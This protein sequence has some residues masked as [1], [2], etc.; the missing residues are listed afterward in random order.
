[1]D[2]VSLAVV[3][4]AYFIGSIDFG[5][6]V[7]RLLGTDIYAHG[8]G[9]PGATNVLRSMGRK[10]AAVVVIGDLAKG[11]LAAMLGGLTVGLSTAVA[12]AFAAVVGHC[13]PVWHR[14][15]GGKG[16]AAAGGAA[17]W[18]EPLLGL[19]VFGV[20]LLVVAVTRKASMA[21]LT[22][23]VVYVPGMVAFGHRGWPLV[24]AGAMA[25][26]IVVRHIPNIRRLLGGAEHAIDSP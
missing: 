10:V 11:F 7:P 22:V 13:F 9:N 2:A 16:V 26:L 25:G 14:F 23:C 15:R 24:W 3:I 6:L 8:S 17:F 4:A 1:V 21:S 5:V 20:W 19:A 18:L 12:C